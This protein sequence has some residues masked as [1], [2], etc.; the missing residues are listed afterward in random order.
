MYGNSGGTTDIVSR[1]DVLFR[2]G[3]FYLWKE[4]KYEAY[5]Y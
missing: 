2:T 5:W 3:L 4:F 1:P